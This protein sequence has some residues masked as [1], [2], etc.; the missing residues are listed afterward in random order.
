[1]T[2]ALSLDGWSK[3]AGGS[4]LSAFGKARGVDVNQTI[5]TYTFPSAASET[6]LL[7]GYGGLVAGQILLSVSLP[8]SSSIPH[9]STTLGLTYV[10]SSISFVGCVP[11]YRNKAGGRAEGMPSKTDAGDKPVPAINPDLA[12]II[13]GHCARRPQGFRGRQSNSDP[14]TN[15]SIHLHRAQSPEQTSRLAR[16]RI[17][18]EAVH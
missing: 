15:E 13:E 16:S 17:R 10:S 8:V 1:M 2:S 4:M 5:L 11:M 9:G 18:H 6:R 14:T 3:M 7:G 12:N